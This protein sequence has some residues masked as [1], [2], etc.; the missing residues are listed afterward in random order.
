MN[1]LN[2]NKNIIKIAR[3][4]SDLSSVLSVSLKDDYTADNRQGFTDA[5]VISAT[6]GNTSYYQGFA[7]VLDNRLNFCPPYLSIDVINRTLMRCDSTGL[8]N[9]VV[10]D[11]L[12]CIGPSAFQYCSNIEFIKAPIGLSVGK[13]AFDG[14]TSLVNIIDSHG[15]IVDPYPPYY[16]SGRIS[17][18]AFRNCNSLTNILLLSTTT[19]IGASAFKNCHSLT[20]V[21]DEETLRVQD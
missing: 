8:N 18:A 3:D 15:P 14:C 9:I 20:S 7:Y 12:T 10:P 4:Y 21:F 1:P 5:T 19:S 17:T 2:I 16:L 6:A 11:Y 13:Y